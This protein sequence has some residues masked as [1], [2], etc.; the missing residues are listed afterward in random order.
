V[1]DRQKLVNNL[2]CENATQFWS[3]KRQCS[4]QVSPWVQV[5]CTFVH[6]CLESHAVVVR[7]VRAKIAGVRKS[8]GAHSSSLT[9]LVHQI[10]FFGAADAAVR[11]LDH[12]RVTTVRGNELAVDVDLCE[13]V[14]CEDT[15]VHERVQACT[16]E[17]RPLVCKADRGAHV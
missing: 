7:L 16:R 14:D 10:T 4:W 11:Q 12:T 9:H 15:C 8:G 3:V 5:Q 2:Q 1:V 17:I 6:V 13:V